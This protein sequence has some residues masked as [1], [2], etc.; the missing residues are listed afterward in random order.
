MAA[1]LM[2]LGACSQG[3]ENS[4]K[5]KETLKKVKVGTTSMRNID[6]KMDFTGSV[7]PFELNF[8]SPS[9][10]VRITKIFVEVGDRVKKGQLLVQMDLSQY[11]QAHTQLE[12]FRVEFTRQDTLYRSGSISLQQLDQIRTQLD[13]A[14]T[15]FQNLK[16]NTQLRSPLSGLVIGRFYENGEMYSMSP[17]AGKPG[18]LSV[19]QINP[20]K[21]KVHV[22]ETFF[23]E[24]KEGMPIQLKLDVYP[25]TTFTGVVHIKYP[26]VDAATRTF[27][28]ETKFPNNKE[29]IRPGM[30]GRITIVFASKTRVVVP[31]M[32]VQRQQGTNEKFVFVLENGKVQ[33]KTVKTGFRVG[34]QF[35][36]LEG[37]SANQK[38]V[39]AGLGGLLEGTPVEVVE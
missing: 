29:L 6:Q 1:L 39:V 15:Q 17:V 31:D 7:E 22:P 30:F 14:E 37:L 5:A 19:A 26:T 35:E 32:A 2:W 20:A 38:V 9:S 34:D 24:V 8:I 12:N 23:P 13:I 21:V 28:V 10:P 18:V 25:D 27:T 11:E 3:A 4:S 33:R 36:V 16:E